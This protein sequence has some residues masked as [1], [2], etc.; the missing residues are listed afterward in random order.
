MGVP[1]GARAGPEPKGMIRR[2]THEIRGPLIHEDESA[3]R[4]RVPRVRWNHIKSG[5]QPCLKRVIHNWA[6]AD[7]EQKSRCMP[8]CVAP[9]QR[10]KNHI[11][12]TFS[13]TFHAYRR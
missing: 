9:L 5:L 8:L 6:G 11:L 4:R 7:S 12:A 1:G 10:L 2:Q 13:R 3:V